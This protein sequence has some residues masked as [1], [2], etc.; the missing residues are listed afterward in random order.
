MPTTYANTIDGKSI[1]ARRAES[2]K[3]GRQIDATYACYGALS[4]TAKSNICKGLHQ[5]RTTL[6]EGNAT[7]G[8]IILSESAWNFEYIEIY[9]ATY[10]SSGPNPGNL[11]SGYTRLLTG[12]N[13]YREAE[14]IVLRCIMIQSTASPSLYYTYNIVG[15]LVVSNNTT[16]SLV[17]AGIYRLP[18]NTNLNNSGWMHIRKIVGVHRIV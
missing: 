10:D 15:V 9:F 12:L 3:G 11:G 2:D 7:K 13:T 16:I 18:D 17:S 4:A 6:F 14:T 1:L 5:D 8:V